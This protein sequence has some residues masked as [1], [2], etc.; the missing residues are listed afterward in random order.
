MLLCITECFHFRPV[1]DSNLQRGLC[2]GNQFHAANLANTNLSTRILSWFTRNTSLATCEVL[3]AGCIRLEMSS[4]CER[5]RERVLTR[6][7]VLWP[8][9]RCTHMHTGLYTPVL[10][11]GM[12]H[13]RPMY[14]SS[15]QKDSFYDWR[16]FKTA[17]LVLSKNTTGD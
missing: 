2:C 13:F 1:Y 8:G 9:A 7:P 5:T 15:L 17:S 6:W 12:F 4:G 14:A 16:N 11:Y 10:H 3:A